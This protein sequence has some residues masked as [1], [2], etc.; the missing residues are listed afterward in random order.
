VHT[1]SDHL[2]KVAKYL[3]WKTAAAGS[4]EMKELEQFL[5]DS[6]DGA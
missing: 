2:G 4:R 5:L 3:T 1:R 6:G